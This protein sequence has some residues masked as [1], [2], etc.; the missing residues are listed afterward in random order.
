MAPFPNNYANVPPRSAGTDPL[1]LRGSRR[2]VAGASGD[3]GDGDGDVGFGAFAATFG[4]ASQGTEVVELGVG[5]LV[6]PAAADLDPRCGLPRGHPAR[7]PSVKR[8]PSGLP[9]V[10]TSRAVTSVLN[11]WKALIAQWAAASSCWS[12]GVAGADTVARR[13]VG[14]VVNSKR[15]LP[16]MAEVARPSTARSGQSHR[17]SSGS[18]PGPTSHNPSHKAERSQSSRRRSAGTEKVTQGIRPS[19]SAN[20]SAPMRLSK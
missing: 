19:R 15:L 4:A 13:D 11:G 12:M 2:L 6:D 16:P 18:P 5:A 20:T 7:R 3:D 14:I 8:F 10:L 1:A 17:S 9:V